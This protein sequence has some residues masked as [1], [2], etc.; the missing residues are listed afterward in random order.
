M[1]VAEGLPDAPPKAPAPPTAGS[2]HWSCVLIVRRAAAAAVGD[3]AST[4]SSESGGGAGRPGGRERDGGG[5]GGERAELGAEGGGGGEARGAAADDGDLVDGVAAGGER[6]RAL[7]RV[8]HERS[9]RRLRLQTLGLE[10]AAGDPG[11]GVAGGG[12]HQQNRGEGDERSGNGS[13]TPTEEAAVPP[14]Q[15]R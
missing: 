12:R 8:A 2:R 4:A 11:E 3:Q 10:P 15:Q 9:Q 13:A 6:N 5:L 1:A 7:D 14:H